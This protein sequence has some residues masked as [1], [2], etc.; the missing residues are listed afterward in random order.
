ML[1]LNQIGIS[2]SDVKIFNFQI[3]KSR[4]MIEK[5]IFALVLKE[6]NDVA[7]RTRLPTSPGC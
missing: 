6:D 4:E 7:R 5:I 2:G 3:S 1:N